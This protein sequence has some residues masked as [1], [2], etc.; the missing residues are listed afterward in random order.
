[1]NVPLRESDP[2]VS[3]DLQAVLNRVYAEGR[4]ESINYTK[5]LDPPLSPAD[6]EWVVSLISR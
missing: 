5:P 1:V 6:A 4:F 3:L 2:D